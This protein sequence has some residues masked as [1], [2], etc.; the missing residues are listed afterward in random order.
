LLLLAFIEDLPTLF[1]HLVIGDLNA[2]NPLWGN[3]TSNPMGNWLPRQHVSMIVPDT[4]TFAINNRFSTIDVLLTQRPE[5]FD[6]IVTFSSLSTSDHLPVLYR[7][8]TKFKV[9]ETK[10]KHYNYQLADWKGYQHFL[11][12]SL[13]LPKL[14]CTLQDLNDSRLHSDL[15]TPASFLT[16]NAKAHHTPDSNAS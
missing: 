10:H 12:E 16:E 2:K 11:F 5:Q 4:H 3:K 7:L 15:C 9:Q 13:P 6:E 8:N 1:A 14:L